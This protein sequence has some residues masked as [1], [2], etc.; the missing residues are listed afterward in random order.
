M[1]GKAP[2]WVGPIA[3]AD[4]GLRCQ[5]ENHREQPVR[6]D[7]AQSMSRKSNRQD[8]A[9][10]ESSFGH[11]ESEFFYRKGFKSIDRFMAKL[12]D[13]I[14]R[15]DDGRM[16]CGLNGMSPVEYGQ[17]HEAIGYCAVQ[18]N[19]RTSNCTCCALSCNVADQP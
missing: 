17:Y 12:D 14:D 10:A 3:R 18:E 11:P 4:R 2:A 15:H 6:I 5:H 7:A 13:C 16:R 8:D 9:P 19:G 1:A